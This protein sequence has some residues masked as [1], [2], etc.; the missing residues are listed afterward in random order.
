M[1]VINK[2]RIKWETWTGKQRWTKTRSWMKSPTWEEA[3]ERSMRGPYHPN[4]EPIFF[5]FSSSLLLAPTNGSWQGSNYLKLWWCNSHHTT[6]QVKEKYLGVVV[7]FFLA[8][9][10][11][12]FSKLLM[13]IF[14]ELI[15]ILR[16]NPKSR[17]DFININYKFL[18]D[19]TEVIK[20]YTTS[21]RSH[22]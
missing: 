13:K 5:F 4:V 11:N 9:G 18:Y 6:Y 12:C 16:I 14:F 7:W 1:D 8:F 20:K 10:D 21:L 15:F 3:V 22:N 2:R 19:F 17:Y